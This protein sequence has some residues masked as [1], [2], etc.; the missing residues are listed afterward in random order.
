[1]LT[2]L[3]GSAGPVRRA[4]AQEGTK[5]AGA[6][7]GPIALHWVRLPETE[8]CISGDALARVVEAKLRRNVFPAPR[9]ASILIEGHVR[10]TPD[11][12]AAALIM[13]DQSG[14]QLGSRELSSSDGTC[15]ELSETLG[16][17][18]AVM[19]DP[20][21]ARRS[22]SPLPSAAETPVKRAPPEDE[23]HS[24]A[25]V[26]GRVLVGITQDPLYGVGGAYERTLGMAGGLRIEVAT[27]AENVVYAIRID[28]E[29]AEALVRVTYAGLAY[30]PLWLQYSRVRLAG[31]AG[32]ELGG[33]RG[34]DNKFP[35]ITAD[36][37]GWWASA[38]ANL[39]LSLVLV[40]GFEAHFA[41]GLA[42]VFGN[43]FK[44]VNPQGQEEQIL[45]KHK[46]PLGGQFDLGLGARF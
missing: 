10:K 33:V 32:V 8:G 35:L 6:A 23:Q 41:G 2:A 21:A 5:E 37:S 29:K 12:F 42:G 30:C 17:V 9:D 7:R 27:F 36:R 28:N 26:F 44:V 31:C 18:L 20:D 43:P 39:R 19:I 45:P 40:R 34:H 46:L 14:K 3:L 13:R 16:V 4:H 1:L 25:L 22:P 15:H 11:G 38:S 24:R